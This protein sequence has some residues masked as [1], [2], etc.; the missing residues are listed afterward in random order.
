MKRHVGAPLVMDLNLSG[1]V[2]V[3]TGASKEIGLAITRSLA[4]EGVRVAA[5]AHLSGVL[6]GITVFGLGLALT[7]APLTSTVL[8]V[9]E[10][11]T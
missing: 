9:V 3:V 10:E 4:A 2:A 8:A 1:K 7:V 5:G 11:A 6:P